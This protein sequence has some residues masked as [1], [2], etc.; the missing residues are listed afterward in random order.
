MNWKNI[1]IVYRKEIIDTLRDKRTVMMMIMVPILLYP[2]LF[3]MMG[4]L[5]TIGTQNLESQKSRIA[6]NDSLPEAL[7]DSIRAAEDFTIVDTENPLSDL[8]AE[9]L[10]GF[11]TREYSGDTL[12]F[13]VYYDAAIDKSRLCEDRLSAALQQY[14]RQEQERLL[15]LESIDLSVL[16]PFQIERENIAT[17]SRMGG[18]LLG[19]IIPLL[20]IVT[21]MLG[22]MYPAIDLTAGEKERGTLETI[23][24][25]PVQ[26]IDLVLGKFLTVTTIALITG[27]LNLASMMLVYTSGMVQMGELNQHMEFGITGYGLAWLFFSL[28]PFA[29]FISA[30][31]LSVCLFARSFK[32]AQNYATP[33]YLL[34]MFP[35]FISMMP[36]IE[37]NR[38]LA[39][40]PVANLSL[41]FREIFL[42]NYPVDLIFLTFI[43][44]AFVA[45][46][47]IVIVVKLFHAESVLFGGNQPFQLSLNRSQIRPADRFQP[48]SA[49]MLFALVML[50]LFYIGSY[51]Q[52]K[53]IIS[54]I[55]ITEWLLIALPVLVFIWFFKVDWK[56][57]L[58]LEKVNGVALLGTVLTG[59][60][61]LG[62]MIW[63]SRLQ[64]EFFPEYE[65]L[66][67][68]L[69]DILNVST[70]SLN[71]LLGVLVF[72]V[73][74]AIC[75]EMLFRGVLLS[76]LKKHMPG[77]MVIVT[78]GFLFGL[79]HINL[80]RIVPTALL[81]ILFTYIV[82]RTRS[83]WPAVLAHLINNG[84]V[85]L[86]IN[87][88]QAVERFPWLAGNSWPTLTAT[89]VMM[90]LMAAG[91]GLIEWSSRKLQ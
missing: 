78:V 41:L 68:S 55:L 57:T 83:I 2:L 18:M 20:L 42:G 9:L 64:M 30:A 8:K 73:S 77:W 11:L 37:L 58:H 85:F 54:G 47:F 81:G 28:I 56:Q 6:L 60:G 5:M 21:M 31:I 88:P 40:V 26:R 53:S 90:A 7:T 91:V 10:H 16:E 61:A 27:L 74:P 63:V 25:I 65:E 59:V 45:M 72:A 1:A 69:E 75:E 17:P 13:V 44:N 3:M 24:T 50:L 12:Q 71:P 48:S 19:S 15:R 4:Q 52:L 89:L 36:G 34:L 62:L 79:F 33:V 35:S 84:I 86:L 43:A 70:T 39:M 29:L 22:A 23:L 46:L 49:L 87:S 67:K 76:S 66:A 82:F 32:E 14:Q 80:Y 38:T 51:V